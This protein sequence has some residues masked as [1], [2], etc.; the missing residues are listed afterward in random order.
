[1]KEKGEKAVQ[2]AFGL[3]QEGASGSPEIQKEQGASKLVGVKTN[4]ASFEL[5]VTLVKVSSNVITA[6]LSD[7]SEVTVQAPHMLSSSSFSSYA[8]TLS[9]SHTYSVG[10]VGQSSFYGRDYTSSINQFGGLVVDMA[11]I[12]TDNEEWVGTGRYCE[13]QEEVF[14][15]GDTR[16]GGISAVSL[17]AFSDLRRGL[18]NGVILLDTEAE[19]L[20]DVV[21]A[22]LDDVEMRQIATPEVRDPLV[23][24]FSKKDESLPLIQEGEQREGCKVYVAKLSFL[25]KPIIA[26]VRL[27]SPIVVQ[28]QSP[29]LIRYF[30]FVLGSKTCTS[31]AQYFYWNGIIC[32]LH[33][34]GRAFSLMMSQN[35]FSSAARKINTDRLFLKLMDNFMTRCTMLPPPDPYAANPFQR[36][37]VMGQTHGCCGKKDQQTITVFM[38][39]TTFQRTNHQLRRRQRVLNEHD[40]VLK[41]GSWEVSPLLVVLQC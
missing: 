18:E 33:E 34:M 22:M 40:N 36:R 6:R 13:G 11:E 9:H 2:E 17:T 24:L 3:F 29:L 32:R 10:S 19:S 16:F 37:N 4:G 1:M 21:N 25:T 31:T 41:T 5:S 30:L 14:E 7:G 15:E 26:M 39:N 12:G 20:T 8:D 28:E 23:Q 38:P 27:K 35:W